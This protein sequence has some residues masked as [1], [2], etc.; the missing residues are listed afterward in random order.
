MTC[1][2]AELTTSSQLTLFAEDFPARTFRTPESV[3]ASAA[4]EADFG[5]KCAEL[6]ASYDRNSCS[7]RTW[8]LCLDGA[9]TEFSETFPKSGMTRNGKLYRLPT[10]EHRTSE[11]GSGFWPTPNVSI[12]SKPLE[13]SETGKLPNGTK[14]QVGLEHKVEMVE[15]GMWPTPRA[16]NPGSRPNGKGGKILSEEVAIAEGLRT[17]GEPLWP[18]PKASPSGPDFAR[19]AREGSGGDDLAT[20]V[21][22]HPT[23]WLTPMA[24]DA[25]PPGPNGQTQLANQVKRWPTPRANDAEKRG[26][27]D[28]TNPRNG[29]AGAAKRWPTPTFEDSQSKGMSAARLE[30]GRP[31]DTL[32]LAV[33]KWPTPTAHDRSSTILSV[34]QQERN[35]IPGM[36]LRLGERPGGQL[37]PNWVEWLMGYPTGWTAL[38]G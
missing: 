3:S 27:F 15:R 4:T 33:Q 18:T 12:G 5:R 20:A 7:W 29:L 16:A 34:S 14:R 35:S 13:M 36:L 23:R 38:R 26:D 28:E 32:H 10:W 19:M 21:A 30:E 25:N 1:A 9:L 8:Q 11:N 24:R 6:L 17:R 22:R 2:A 37:N 31:P